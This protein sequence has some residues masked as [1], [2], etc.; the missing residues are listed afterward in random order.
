MYYGNEAYEYDK[1]GNPTKY[2]DLTCEWEKGRQLKGISYDENNSITFGYDIY[3]IRTEKAV[4]SRDKE[5]AAY[6]IYEN[7]KLLRELCGATSID[8][9]YGTEGIAGFIVDKDTNNEATYIYRKNIFGDVTAVYNDDGILQ[10][11]YEYDAW[12]NHIIYDADGKVVDGNS[13]NIGLINPIRYRGYYFDEETGL[14]YLKTRYYDPQVGRFMTIDGIEYLDPETINGL[15]L[16]AYCN[17]NPVM[18]VDPDGTWSWKTFWKGLALV[19]IAIVATVLSV[20]TF[21]AGI[22]LAM[23]IVAGVT[24]GAGIL[25]GINGVATVIEAGTQ[26]NFVRDGIFNGLGLSDNAYDIY[27]KVV[28]G[29]AIV[30]SAILGF[31]HTTGQYKAAKASQKYLGKGYLKADKNR[32]IS[33]DGF[34]QVRWDTTHHIYKGKPSPVH[35][36]WYEYKYPIANGVRNK[37][38]KDVHV[39][40]KWFSFFIQG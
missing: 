4:K 33:K 24:L 11:T 25:T 36:N 13:D 38:I 32:W 12:G 37:L 21:G 15:N 34:R 18:N 8:Y 35:F 39:W 30:G 17:N 10:C 19:A 1:L 3:G 5:S 28:A 22:P 23:S 31:Y 27:D 16:Y 7:G 40:I 6:Y 2:R 20:T 26:Y 9:I 14:Y 29:V